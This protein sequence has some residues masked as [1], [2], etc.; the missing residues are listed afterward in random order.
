VEPETRYVRGSGGQLAYQVVGDGPIDLVYLTGAAS[1]VDVRW[2]IPQ[3]VR[4]NQRLASF[5]RLIMFDRLGNGASDRT[6]AG[7]VQSLPDWAEDLCAVLDTVGSEQ[8]AILAVA[9][10]GPMAMLFAAS[11]PDRVSALVLANTSASGIAG[12]DYPEEVEREVL[13]SV[14]KQVEERWGT[15]EYVALICP[16]LSADP[17]AR[18]LYARQQRASATPGMSA[19]QLK[20]T[21]ELDLRSVLPTIRARTLVLHR[22]D[23]PRV[24]VDHARYLAEHIPGATLIELDGADG[25]LP[26]GDSDAVLVAVEEFLTGARA[27]DPDRVLATVLFTDLVRSTARAAELG[28]R[29]WAQ[30]LSRHDELVSEQ[31]ERFHGRVENHRGRS[32][33]HLR[34]ASRCDQVCSVGPRGPGGSW[35]G[36]A[37]RD[38]R[39]R[40]RDSRRGHWGDRGARRRTGDGDCRSPRDTA[41]PDRR[42]SDRRLRNRPSPAWNADPQGRARKMEALRR[43]R[44]TAQRQ[45]GCRECRNDRAGEGSEPVLLRV[46]AKLP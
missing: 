8:T 33:C 18:R 24:P 19:A 34:H 9:D 4:F 38:A 20:A 46:F 5:S 27:S 44:L 22:R 21:L 45:S 12:E 1:H 30:L 26:F 11:Y 17:R 36:D 6:V 35:F 28:D 3:S 32:P 10:A 41:L 14:V 7:E 42:R 31:V 16:S 15:E 37:G 43:R 25:A 2:E 39:G 13:E 40:G 23:F 29:K